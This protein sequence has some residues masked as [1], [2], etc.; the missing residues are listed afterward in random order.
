MVV[1]NRIIVTGVCSLCSDLI[2]LIF[3]LGVECYGTHAYK[4][5]A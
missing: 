4:G 3:L 5:G 1:L 2:Q